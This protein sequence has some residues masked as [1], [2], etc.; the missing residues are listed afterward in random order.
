M[1][2]GLSVCCQRRSFTSLAPCLDAEGMIPA[3]K[4]DELTEVV[5]Q[6]LRVAT[7]HG[8]QTVRCVATAAVR[9][10]RN[11][12][13]LVELIN[14]RCGSLRV[15]ILDPQAEARL[16]FIGA[17]WASQ[18]DPRHRIAVID[19]GGGSTEIVVGSDPT[20]L[21]WRSIGV[22]SG[23][24]GARW[25]GG[26]CVSEAQIGAARAAVE[27][28]IAPIDV[29][30]DVERVIAVAGSATARLS[31]AGS[32]SLSSR[33]AQLERLA[34]GSSAGDL[35]RRF[36]VEKHRGPLLLAGAIIISAV[37]RRFEAPLQLVH[38]GLRE[39]L[40]LGEQAAQA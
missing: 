38:G 37:A 25:F 16:A 10:A 28:V 8:A 29:P 30:T 40:L 13:R 36:G 34:A 3:D 14:K 17:A 20:K 31:L 9:T 32:S 21:W 19:V 39:G 33:V 22:G 5:C 7:E 1:A 24:L 26:T 11:S 27:T 23:Q 12:T 18:V 6:Q 35:A 4:L 2:D 15:E